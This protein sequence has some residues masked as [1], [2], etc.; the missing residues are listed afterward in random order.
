MVYI[1]PLVIF[2]SAVIA[3]SLIWRTVSRRRSLPCPSWLSWIVDNPLS[4]ARTKSTLS[5]LGLSPG[6]NVLDAG[7]GPGRLTIPIA[8]AVGSHGLVLAVD[9]QPEM[10]RRARAKAT[11]ASVTNV[12]FLHAA[13]GGGELPRS[14]FD[15]AVL[16]TV[17]GEIPDRLSA[18]RE[19]YSALRP[20]GFLLVSEVMPDPHYQSLGKVKA[21]AQEAGFR[22]GTIYGNRFAFSIKLEKPHGA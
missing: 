6:H 13:L 22:S 16:V 12:Q 17:L 14:L 18:L 2:A 15:C 21:L 3:V 9:I 7:C 8:Q 11:Q 19:I 4:K 10:L 1:I 5:L 20:G